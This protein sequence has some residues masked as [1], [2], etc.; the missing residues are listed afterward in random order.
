MGLP[1]ITINIQSGNLNRPAADTDTVAGLVLS[2]STLMPPLDPTVLY[3]VKQA[4]EIWGYSETEDQQNGLLHYEHIKEFFAFNPNGELHVI[5]TDALTTIEQMLGDSNTP[6]LLEPWLL[7]QN[8][9]IK[10]LAIM[11]TEADSEWFEDNVIDSAGIAKAQGLANRMADR[12]MALDV[13]FLE[14]HGF[15]YSAANLPDLRLGRSRNVAV[16]VGGDYDLSVSQP[17][18]YG[19]AALGT[20]LGM[21]TNKALHDSFAR[22]S[23][24]NTL[25]RANDNRFLRVRY[26]HHDTQSADPFENDPT[27]LALLHERGYVFPRRLPF[28]S[29]YYWNQSSNCTRTDDD[30]NAIELVQVINKAARLT[31]TVLSSYINATHNLTDSGRLTELRRQSI[32]AE[33]NR[34]LETNMAD[35]YSALEALVLDPE[36]DAFQ[37]PYPSLVVDPTLRVGF[38]I[39]PRGKT[40]SINVNIALTA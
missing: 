5:T 35:N 13:I 36:L 28:R 10:Q 26:R 38:K 25:T 14:G 7:S 11:A 33:I 27:A 18:Y 9:R 23:D 19:Y 8:G 6:G 1:T 21:S 24:G 34:T 17:E 31:A 12:F 20:A 30:L 4:E 15:N 32:T 2:A 37:T 3:S 29:G 40:E 39:R 16:V 22:A